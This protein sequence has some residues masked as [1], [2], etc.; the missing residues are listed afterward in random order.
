M[1]ANATEASNAAAK[2]GNAESKK[3]PRSRRT[4]AADVGEKY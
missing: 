1:K 3:K 4:K 2:G